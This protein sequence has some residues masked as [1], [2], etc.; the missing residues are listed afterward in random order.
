M[1]AR[2]RNRRTRIDPT[3]PSTDHSTLPFVLFCLCLHINKG[4]IFVCLLC[5]IGAIGSS[6]D[7]FFWPQGR[8][9]YS[10][11]LQLDIGVDFLSAVSR[12]AAQLSIRHHSLSVSLPLT[13]TL[14]ADPCPLPIQLHSRR[15]EYLLILL[16]LLLRCGQLEIVIGNIIATGTRWIWVSACVGFAK[17]QRQR[18]LLTETIVCAI[19]RYTNKHIMRK[20]DKQ[21][22]KT[23]VIGPYKYLICILCEFPQGIPAKT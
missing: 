4:V 13:P 22:E 12:R 15:M 3:R 23:V 1:Q 18:D 2:M 14:A 17:R 16:L 19:S 21:T 5:L 11:S 10:L 7:A 9:F 20:G 8:G 6:Q